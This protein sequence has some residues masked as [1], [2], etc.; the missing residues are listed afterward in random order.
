VGRGTRLSHLP[1]ESRR[2]TVSPVIPGR[3]EW[4]RLTNA[5]VCPTTEALRSTDV[6][7]PDMVK[8]R[9]GVLEYSS[10]TEVW[11]NLPRLELFEELF[12][13]VVEPGELGILYR[14]SRSRKRMRGRN[15][16]GLEVEPWH[17]TILL[18]LLYPEPG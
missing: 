16:G 5:R 13:L 15:Q 8:L 4:S 3:V 17:R 12:A 9:S 14:T 7:R 11:S 6:L 18:R 1:V 10:T 2:H